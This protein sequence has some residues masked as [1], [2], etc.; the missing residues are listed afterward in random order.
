MTPTAIPIDPLRLRAVG[1]HSGEL[2][3]L[4]EGFASDNNYGN[5]SAY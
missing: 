2:D 5:C 4:E 1:L 3:A